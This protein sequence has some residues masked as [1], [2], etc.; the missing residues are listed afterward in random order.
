MDTRFYRLALIMIVAGASVAPFVSHAFLP[1]E[2][3]KL[4]NESEQQ[5]EER[6]EQFRQDVLEKRKEVLTKWHDRR[7]ILKEKIK[8][9]QNRIKSDFELRRSK[10][11]EPRSATSTATTTPAEHEAENGFFFTIKQEA[12]NFVHA[13]SLRHLFGN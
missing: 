1:E 2:L 7:E 3:Q 8:E 11:G 9:E 6:R 12:Q 10:E 4:H 5:R 13:F